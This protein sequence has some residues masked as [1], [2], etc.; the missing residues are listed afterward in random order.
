MLPNELEAPWELEYV[1]LQDPSLEDRNYYLFI[2]EIEERKARKSGVPTEGEIM[3]TARETGYWGQVED[4][5]EA[6]ADNHIAFLEAE[7]ESKK[8][9]KSRQNIIK[10]QLEDARAKKEWVERKRSDLKTK[11]SGYLAHEI[12]SL[13]LLKR[14]AYKPDS[15]LLIPDDET[16]LYLKKEYIV[17]LFYLVQDVMLEGTLETHEL[18]EVARSSEWRLTWCLARENLYS[19]FGRAIGD[20]T[21]NHKLLIYWSRVYDSAFEDTEPPELSVIKD[22][23]LF[24][25]WLSNK[26]LAMK[27]HKKQDKVSSAQEQGRMLDGTYIET[28]SCGAKQQNVGKYLGEKTRHADDCLF[29][30]WHKYSPEEKETQ[31]AKIY[32]RNTSNIRSIIDKEQE[33]VL[34]RGLVEEQHLRGKTTRSALG[35]ATKTI[36]MKRR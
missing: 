30:T 23:E 35:M 36:P 28:C 31:A 8:K 24:D 10:V 34:K 14:L 25:Q 17:F 16:L 4:D 22:D 26:D 1:V 11:S 3:E 9:F 33:S 21:M 5:I 19:I 2:R 15:T 7:F 6:K 13:M 27:D 12:A 29:G 32:G 18:R 20:F